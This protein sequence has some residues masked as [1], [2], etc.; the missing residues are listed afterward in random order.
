MRLITLFWLTA[1]LLA[2]GMQVFAQNNGADPAGQMPPGHGIKCQKAD[3]SPCG[4]PEINNLKQTVTDAKTTVSDTQSTVS[5]TQQNVS[6]AKQVGGDAQQVGSDMKKPLANPKQTVSDVKQA[7]GDVKSAVGDV[8][9][10]KSD[11][12]QAVQDVQQNVE[13]AKKTLKGLAGIKSI[14]LK[15]L[16]GSMNCAQSDGTA[17]TDIQTKALQAQAAQKAP[18]LTIT[19]EVDQLNN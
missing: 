5:D 14:A 13:D 4:D 16:D 8:Q 17:C 1:L 3:G 15:A 19:R 18:P 11:A 2:T 7:V 6:D 9:Q 10:T 12:Q